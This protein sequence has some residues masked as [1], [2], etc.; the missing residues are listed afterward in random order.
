[1]EQIETYIILFI[2]IVIIGQ[3]FSKTPV[4]ISLLLVITG[5]LLSVL[6]NPP[7]VILDPS[8]VLNVFLPLLIY[9]ISAFSSWKD[10]KKNLRPIILLS[11]GHVMFITLLVAVVIHMLVPEF[12][13]PLA[14]VLGAVISPPDDVAIVS[15]ADKIRM[16]ERIVTILEGEGMFNDATALILFRFALAAVITHQFSAIQAVSAFFFVVI[17]ETLYGL[18]LGFII[19]ELRLRIQ[20]TTLNMM[21]SLLVPFIAYIPPV[22]LGGSGVLSTAITGFV[23]GNSYALRVSPE[24]RLVSRAVWP[25]LAFAIQSLMFLLVGLDMRSILES[26]SSLPPNSVLIYSV[27][28]ILTVIIGRFIWVYPAAYLP[29]WL[30]PRIRKKDP[31]PPW[32]FPFVVSWAGMRGGI[33]LAAALAVPVLPVI[34]QGTNPKDLLI[35]LV[36]CVIMATLL[37][38]GLTLPWLL[39]VLGVHK[40]GQSEKY[41]EHLAEL[42]ARLA[43]VRTALR[44]LIEFKKQVKDNPKLLDEVKLYLR[45]YRMLRSQLKERIAGHDSTPVLMHDEK[46]DWKDEIFILSQLIELQRMELLELWRQDK[47]NLTVRNK[48]LEQL[49]HSAKHLPG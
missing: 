3:T 4:P 2:V 12:G 37:I 26:I 20:N 30:F 34:N 39:K 41:N 11:I 46:E 49:D 15:I 22:M 7:D 45:E 29:R 25:T 32:Q 27:A 33:S 5:M 47:I 36:F 18:A 31:Y 35:F 16:P 21:A 48:L 17:G 44:W 24:F 6:P 38:Q 42:G 23:F 10:V 13:W 14:F 19:G 9:Q 28:V 43:M 8:I 40:F 1:M